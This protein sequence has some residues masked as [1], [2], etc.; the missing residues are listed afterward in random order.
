M[1]AGRHRVRISCVTEVTNSVLKPMGV[2]TGQGIS[3]TVRF[4]SCKAA[5]T[6]VRGVDLGR[7]LNTNPQ[8]PSLFS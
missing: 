6:P 7:A 3:R 8:N 5:D 2:R 4:L 1:R